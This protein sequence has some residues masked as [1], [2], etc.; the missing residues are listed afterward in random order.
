M[1]SPRARLLMGTPMW[2]LAGLLIMRFASITA[3]EAQYPPRFRPVC[4]R[5]ADPPPAGSVPAAMC[6]MSRSAPAL[7]SPERPILACCSIQVTCACSMR[8]VCLV[9]S[10]SF[11]RHLLRNEAKGLFSSDQ[12]LRSLDVIHCLQDGRSG[13]RLPH[14]PMASCQVLARVS[15]LTPSF[16]AT[17]VSFSTCRSLFGR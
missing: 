3:V 12:S 13:A 6:A 7:P 8:I 1:V 11:L 10:S 15:A 14:G 4:G 17:S 5:V 2:L 16:P 9:V